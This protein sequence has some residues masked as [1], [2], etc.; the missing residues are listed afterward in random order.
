MRIGDAA[1]TGFR[2]ARPAHQET[3]RSRVRDEGSGGPRRGDHARSRVRG[4]PTCPSGTTTCRPLATTASSRATTTPVFGWAVARVVEGR[5]LPPDPGAVA[6]STVEERR[7]SPDEPGLRCRHWPS[8]GP[9]P[10]SGRP[11]EVL[12]RVLRRRRRPRP[13]VRGPPCRGLRGRRRVR[14]ALGD[15]LLHVDGHRARAAERLRPGGDRARRRRRPPASSYGWVPIEVPSVLARAAR[16]CQPTPADLAARQWVL[17]RGRCRRSPGGSRPR[18]GRPV[19]P[20]SGATPA[21]TRWPSGAWP[22]ATARWSARRASAATCRDTTDL[23]GEVRRQRTW[24]SCF[25]LD[26]SY[27]HG[28]P[29]RASTRSRYRQWL[30]HKLSTW[31]DQ[32]DTSGCVGCGR[33]IAWCP[34]GIDLTEEAAAITGQLTAPSLSG[35][36]DR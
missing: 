25:D 9:D 17:D 34:V 36:S 26:H 3:G 12:D 6:G 22:V 27:L 23:A 29:V 28:G 20:Q 19:G 15:L 8:S 24:A 31:W 13:A 16:H 10:A 35:R 30:T 33:C 14:L 1:V 4:W 2:R 11:R 21:G 18:A 32:F 7:P 5:V